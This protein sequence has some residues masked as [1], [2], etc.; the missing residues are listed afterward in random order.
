ML[1]LLV[2]CCSAQT[3]TA[4]VIIKFH[5]DSE[6]AKDYYLLREPSCWTGSMLDEPSCVIKV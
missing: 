6:I 3:N 2:M 1:L 4:G 5:Y